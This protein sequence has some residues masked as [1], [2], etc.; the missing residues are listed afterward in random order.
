MVTSTPK[1]LQMLD[2]QSIRVMSNQEYLTMMQTKRQ[3]RKN[4]LEGKVTEEL[5][6]ERT[7]DLRV[8]LTVGDGAGVDLDS[9]V[10]TGDETDANEDD[11]PW[12]LLKITNQEQKTTKYKLRPDTLVND[13]IAQYKRQ[14][15]LADSIRVELEFDGEPLEA[16]NPIS[17][18][19]CENGDQLS[20]RH[21][22]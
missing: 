18:Y 8:D 15:A 21:L 22:K 20:A 13:L 5:N 17:T 11:G 14:T 9:Y 7:E 12:L 1:A 16:D 3:Q 2:K 4:L 19:D 6:A 10:D